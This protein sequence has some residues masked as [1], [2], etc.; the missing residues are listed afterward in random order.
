MALK[1]LK[2]GP[3]GSKTSIRIFHSA[4]PKISKLPR[5]HTTAEAWNHTKLIYFKQH[6]VTELLAVE[7]MQQKTNLLVNDFTGPNAIILSGHEPINF[8]EGVGSLD[9]AYLSY[10]F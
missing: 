3:V 4:L 10:L 8:L 9:F 6:M 1:T 7:W 2:V 5:P